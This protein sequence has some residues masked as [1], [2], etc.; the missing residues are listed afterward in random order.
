MEWAFGPLLEPQNEVHELLL[1]VVLALVESIKNN[2]GTPK[3]G[4]QLFEDALEI[5]I[6]RQGLPIRQL[7]LRFESPVTIGRPS[8]K[9]EDDAPKPTFHSVALLVLEV[10]VEEGNS[11][12]VSAVFGESLVVKKCVDD[13]GAIH[14]SLLA[15]VK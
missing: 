7:V 3:L 5:F 12:R 11:G 8:G 10:E 1:L 4:E 15:A 6:G 9:L 13:G 2:I 14:S